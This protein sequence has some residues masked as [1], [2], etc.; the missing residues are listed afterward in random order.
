MSFLGKIFGDSNERYIK[1]LEPIVER[2][3]ALEKNF[4]NLSPEEL[5]SSSAKLKE[6]LKNGETLDA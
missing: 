4:K 3:N 5:K 6:R 2:V 1:S